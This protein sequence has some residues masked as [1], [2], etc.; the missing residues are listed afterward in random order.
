V[1][2]LCN[3]QM[4]CACT[5]WPTLDGSIFAAGKGFFELPVFSY[6]EGAQRC[7]AVFS[8]TAVLCPLCNC[9]MLCARSSWPTLDRSIFAAG[10]LSTNISA[11]YFFSSQR[12]A[13]VPR[14]T[15]VR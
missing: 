10:Y 2:V 13:D 9:Q 6:H 7:A 4:L 3:S 12:H 1:R 8:A 15:Q 14:L 5:S 11:N